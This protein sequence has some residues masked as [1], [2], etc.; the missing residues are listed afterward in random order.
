L[1]HAYQ[2]NPSYFTPRTAI[3][4]NVGQ[5]RSLYSVALRDF[6]TAGVVSA[7]LGRPLTQLPGGHYPVHGQSIQ[8]NSDRV[9]ECLRAVNNLVAML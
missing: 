1:F 2:A 5:F 6:N 9:A 7:H 8:V 3:A 4:T